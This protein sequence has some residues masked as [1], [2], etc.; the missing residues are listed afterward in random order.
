[1]NKRELGVLG[2]DIASNFLKANGVEIIIRNYFTKFGEIDIIGIEKKTIIFIE[3]KLRKSFKYGEPLESINSKKLM[4][5][6]NSA[7][8]FLSENSLFDSYDCRFD[9]V[10]L[11]YSKVTKTFKIEWFKNQFLS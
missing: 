1:M 2:E 6:K 5:I 10:C 9:I 7:D 11:A 4:R 8:F 3:V